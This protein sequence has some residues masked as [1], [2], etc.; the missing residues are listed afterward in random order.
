MA[1]ISD[2]ALKEMSQGEIIQQMMSLLT[3]LGKKEKASS[4]F[5]E[6]TESKKEKSAPPKGVRP[7]QLDKSTAWVEYV[8]SHIVRNGWESF[9][10]AERFGSG[11][12]NI[13]YTESVLTP[14]V[15]EDGNP[16][17]DADGDENYAHVFVG[18]VKATAPN[19]DQP[20]M[21]HAMSLS[22]VY[23]SAAKKT[24][25][26]PELYEEFLAQY[27]APPTPEGSGSKVKKVVERVTLTL[28]EKMDAKAQ[29]EEEKE[30]EK[31]RKKEERAEKKAEREAEKEAE[32]E[33][34]KAEKEGKS[35]VP[36]GAVK[37]IKTPVPV[38]KVSSS[39]PAIKATH[40][41]KEDWV[42]PSGGKSKPFV[43]K[44]VTYL[45]NADNIMWP[46]ADGSAPIGVYDPITKSISDDIS[47][48]LAK[49]YN[50]A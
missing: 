25:S 4:K 26:K 2:S 46:E 48:E 3:V 13:Q 34:K 9:L 40:A 11:M 30:A 47:D 41:V 28:E 8:H 39:K 29:R 42:A 21:S 16:Q 49:K 50:I 36:K 19:G 35:K 23:W 12:A 31:Q 5:V 17:M 15:D 44:G 20:N 37:A 10:H 1:H 24:G 32:K 6:K 14:L 22:K 45:R 38:G 18:S 27:V 7:V 33:R 43:L